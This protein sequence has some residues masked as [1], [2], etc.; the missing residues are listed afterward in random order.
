MSGGRRRV[1]SPSELFKKA[2]AE[3]D[4][5]GPRGVEAERALVWMLGSPRSG[6]TWLLNLLTVHPR[7]VPIDE[8]GIGYHLGLYVADVM[9]T[10]PSS[11]EEA[12]ALLPEARSSDRQYF[13]SGAYEEVWR[14]RLRTMV[15][16]RFHAQ[17]AEFARDKGVQDPVGV[18]KEP[19]GSHAAEFLFRLLPA[20]RLLFL[21]RDPRDVLDS[22]LDAVHGGS[23]LATQFG[24]SGEL[25]A[26]ERL[27]LLA[28]QAH[29]W[30]ART[31]AVQRTYD[32]LPSSQRYLVRYEDLRADTATS[33]RGVL[34]WL[35]LDAGEDRVRQIVERLSFE[36]I[37]E[38]ERGKGRFTRAAAPGTWRENLTA[39]EQALVHETLGDALVRYGYEVTAP[40][41]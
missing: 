28:G 33:L 27:D 8:P 29:R 13:F 6:S 14:P 17:L 38:S 20:S 3:W 7:V 10:H 12:H 31:E 22:I 25:S 18:I 35:G 37:P 1:G 16:A 11:F 23:W 30:L 40:K 5:R 32:R 39:E 21:M 41:P 15:L 9:G 36:A 19:A 24:A 26:R 2:R 4:I 34:R